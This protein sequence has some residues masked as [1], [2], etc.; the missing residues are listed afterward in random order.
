[1][2]R[3]IYPPRPKTTIPPQQLP[4]EESRGIWLWQH[5]FNG[6]RCVAIVDVS[7]S[8]RNVTFCNRHGKF[9]SPLKLQ[10]LTKQF[11]SANFSLPVGTHYLDGELIGDSLVLFDVIQLSNYL[12]GKNQVERLDILSK[13]CGNPT[14]PCGQKIALSITDNIWMARNGDRDFL[15]HYQEYIDSDLIEGLVLRKK[16][17]CLDNWGAKEYEVDWQLR[18]RKPSKKYRF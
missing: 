1:M 9:H 5:K 13:I 2:P 4:L 7:A 6:D 14:E 10:S 12:I 17:F 16:D 18:C 8:K 11:S 3:Y 15:M